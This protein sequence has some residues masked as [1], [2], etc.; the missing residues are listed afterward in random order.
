MNKPFIHCFETPKA[1]YF[2]DVNTNA[3]VRVSSDLYDYLSEGKKKHCDD[4]NIRRELE[5][6]EM[7]GMLS[8][9]KWKVI[10]HPASQMLLENLNG[11][12]EMLTLQIT[13]QCNLRCNYC[14]YSGSYYNRIHSNKNMTIEV[15][16]KTID[17]YIKHSFDKREINIGFYG[18]E[19][20]IQYDLIKNIVEYT[21][22]KGEGKKVNYHITTNATLLDQE[23]ISFLSSHHFKMTISL[24]G[25]RELHDKNRKLMSGKGSFDKVMKNIQLIQKHYPDYMKEIMFNCVVDGQGDYGC[26]NEF[27]TNYDS[28][29]ES[30]TFFSDI[31]AEGIKD[32]DMLGYNEEYDKAYQYEV[33]KLLL[34]KCGFISEKEI[35]PIVKSYYD[36]IK[37]RLKGRSEG[38]NYEDSGHPGGPCIPGIHKLFVNVNGDFY[39]CEKLNENIPEIVIGNIENGFDYQ[40]IYNILNIGKTTQN[41]CKN[42]WCSRFC[43]QC[44]LFSECGDRLS[45]KARL[46]HCE[47]VKSAT[48]NLF[49]DYCLIK[50]VEA[51][52]NNIYFL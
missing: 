11:S 49:L 36:V 4:G 48:E 14:P 41:E 43:Y 45:E 51:E 31:A 16:K 37:M 39:P 3:I 25:P 8:S 34:S 44:V 52:D 12:I 20:I 24:D 32:D 21:E 2:Y 19:P 40:K 18:G 9:E 10:E 27:F 46:S 26:L 33:F 7:A 15:A 23:K 13:Q 30:N 29:K 22:V 42:C 17:F 47:A 35:S 28:V 6:L 5:T 1:K 50:E 38:Y